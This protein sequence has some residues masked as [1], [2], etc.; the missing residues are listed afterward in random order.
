MSVVVPQAIGIS[1]CNRIGDHSVQTMVSDL[2]ALQP[3]TVLIDLG[4]VILHPLLHL[5]RIFSLHSVFTLV[6]TLIGVVV[7]E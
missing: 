2:G 5:W 6:F 1:L 3:L 7:D 4:M